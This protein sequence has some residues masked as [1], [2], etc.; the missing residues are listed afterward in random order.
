MDSTLENIFGHSIKDAK[1]AFDMINDTIKRNDNHLNVIKHT[2]NTENEMEKIKSDLKDLMKDDRHIFV[3]EKHIEVIEKQL[4]AMIRKISGNVQDAMTS[5][6]VSEDYKQI[7]KHLN[8]LKKEILHE[9]KITRKEEVYE[10]I[11]AKLEKEMLKV[12]N[13]EKFEQL[14]KK[15]EKRIIIQLEGLKHISKY[16]HHILNEIRYEYKE[17]SKAL[18]A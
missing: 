9:M 2:V 7:E 1:N 12:N 15:L 13:V 17:V 14:R 11:E 3:E 5:E 10:K 6:S 18:S 8:L 16:M 4:L